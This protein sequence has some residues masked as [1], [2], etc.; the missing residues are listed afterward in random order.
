MI[1]L[2]AIALAFAASGAG[3]DA[4]PRL[5]TCLVG[6]Y[7]G[8]AP[9]IAAELELDSDGR[10]RFAMSY[11]ALDEGAAGNWQSD[12]DTV[13]LTSDETVAPRFAVV[14]DVPN[15][16]N[17]LRV[18]LD[19]PRGLSPQYFAVT[20]AFADGSHAG[21]QFDD[22]SIE[23]SGGDAGLPRSLRVLLPVFDLASDTLPV[24]APGGRDV[25][26]RFEPNDLGAV[27]FAR[28]ALAR[29]D[30]LLLLERHGRVLRFRQVSGPCL[31]KLDAPR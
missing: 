23:F 5:P 6:S 1:Q 24:A 8:G 25:T 27:A 9:E 2:A 3:P 12:G 29:R 18:R 11:G 7:D 17:V 31:R 16:G 13:Y 10:F 28:T 26:V 30:G 4:Q 21:R 19:L 14:G 20:A 22:D 15:A